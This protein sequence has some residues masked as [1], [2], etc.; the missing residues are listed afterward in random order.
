MTPICQTT[1]E[2]MRV[3]VFFFCVCVYVWVCVSKGSVPTAP[4][5]TVNLPAGKVLGKAS[6]AAMEINRDAWCSRRG[7]SL[8]QF[9][10]QFCADSPLKAGKAKWGGGGL[11]SLRRFTVAVKTH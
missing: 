7:S 9:V 3:Y 4:H 6:L 11:K 10:I 5:V 1:K 2:M 8:A